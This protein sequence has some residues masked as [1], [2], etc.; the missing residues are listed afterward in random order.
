MTLSFDVTAQGLGR[1]GRETFHRAVLER[2]RALPG[3]RAAALAETLPLAGRAVGEV[4]RPVG[5]PPGS[6]ESRALV[7]T[8]SPGYLAAL[9]I[10]L[11]AGRDLTAGDS[12]GAPPVVLVNETLAARLWPGR[13]PLGQALLAGEPEAAHEVV[14][15]V[16]DGAYLRVGEPP[17]PMVYASIFQR[18]PVLPDTTLV[19]WCGD[20]SATIEELRETLRGLD[21]RLPVFGVRTLDDLLAGNLSER[22]LGSALIA[23]FGAL[24]LLLAVVGLT[25]VLL[26]LVRERTREIGTR[27]ALGAT[28][29]AIVGEFLRFGIRIGVRGVAIGVPLAVAAGGLLRGLL[30]GVDATDA[31]VVAGVAL[32][33]TLL[34][35]A[36][37]TLPAWLAANVDPVDALR[38]E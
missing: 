24:A 32:L 11:V 7:D 6:G 25:G 36:A 35:A 5:Q 3:V 10:E 2:I 22:R 18:D 9:G 20:S 27:L 38:T 21:P 37:S 15:V 16:R 14:G 34:V 23:A 12:R 26:H 13:S 4:V 28:T 33:L 19:A 17:R 8:V 30:L 1:E 29:A 31:A